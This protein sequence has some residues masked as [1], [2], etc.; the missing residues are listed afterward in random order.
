MRRRPSTRWAS[1]RVLDSLPRA[2]GCRCETAAL[3]DR[4]FGGPGERGSLVISGASGIVG[5]GKAMQLGSRLQPYGVRDRR[6]SICP[7]APDGIGRQYAGLVRAF[8]PRGRRRHHAEH[9]APHLRRHDAARRA[10][11]DQAA[12]PARSDPRDAGASSRR[13][14]RSSARPSPASRSARS[15]PASPA[16]SSASAI[17]HPAFPHEINKVWEIVEREPSPITQLLWSLGL[18]PVPVSDD[19]S[20]VLDV[21]FCGV[22]HA[23]APVPPR[24]ATCRSGR[25]TSSSAGSSGPN[26]FRAHDAIGAQGATF[27]TWSC[28][29][30]LWRAVRR[31]FRPT[32]RTRASTRTR[33]RAGIRR[34]TSARSS[35]GR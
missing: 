24:R 25:S 35:T 14:T 20:F 5:A 19:W 3:V 10:Q 16:G 6:R 21:L 26:P 29:H 28:L 1:A 33:A 32:R 11:A 18:I 34:I 7:G 9:R 13:T 2:A 30:H 12:L 8:G 31:L 4:V 15:R 17:A 22:T 23:A 27:L